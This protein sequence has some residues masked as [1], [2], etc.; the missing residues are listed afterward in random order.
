[1]STARAATGLGRLAVRRAAIPSFAAGDFLVDYRDR[2]LGEWAVPR[3]L[4]PDSWAHPLFVLPEVATLRSEVT[5]LAGRV[6]A[7]HAAVAEFPRLPAHGDATP[8][9]L[10]RPRSAPEEFVLIDWG[11]ATDAPI[12]FDLVPLVFGRA[13]SGLGPAGEVPGLLST[14]V[15]A[16][17]RGLHTEGM[18]VSE[19]VV[20][21][22]VLCAAMS[23][24][25]CTGLPV[26]ALDGE[27]VEPDRAVRKAAFVR[28]VLDLGR[29]LA[30]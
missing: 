22:A 26:Q 7:V 1:V 20:R 6:P 25:P 11:T 5:T 15:G 24:Y 23:R 29:E 10:L 14:A 28:M 30:A 13:E 16:Y 19:D 17:T 9:N 4:A 27:P 3:L 8:M 18:H 2:M 12:G 21:R